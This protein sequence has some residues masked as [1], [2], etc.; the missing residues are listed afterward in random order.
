MRSDKWHPFKRVIHLSGIHLGRFDCITQRKQN[1][2]WFARQSAAFN[3]TD[4]RFQTSVSILSQTCLSRSLPSSR[5]MLMLFLIHTA[6]LMSLPVRYRDRHWWGELQHLL[7]NSNVL[8]AISNGMWAVKLKSKKKS[9]PI[10]VTERWARSW[11]QCTGSQ[12][13][14]DVKWI[15]P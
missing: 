15:T 2:Q 13:A 12:P 9:F 3:R 8:V 5:L 6:S 10:L 11:S 7:P 14:G 1:K 4:F